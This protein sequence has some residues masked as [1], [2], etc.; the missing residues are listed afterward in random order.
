MY[1]T[2]NRVNGTEALLDAGELGLMNTPKNAYRIQPSW[3]WAADNGCFGKGYPG[4][5]AWV[6]WLESFTP[7]Q[8][9]TC[10]FATAPDVVGDGEASLQRSLPW[11]PVIRDLG[12]PVAL[13]TQ[14]GMTPDDIPWPDVDWLFIGGSD[15]H[16]LGPEAKALIAAAHDH[17]KRV[18]VGRVNSQR[19]FLAMAALGADSVDGTYLGFGPDQNLPKLLAWKR[20]LDTQPSLL[21][22]R[23]KETA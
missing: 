15:E 22:L 8:R 14:D 2:G 7:E 9:S 17:G 19:R 21:N 6:A 5:E 10:L 23:T 1:L 3:A 20:H 16:K 13:V 18:H 4:D 12:Y 11:L